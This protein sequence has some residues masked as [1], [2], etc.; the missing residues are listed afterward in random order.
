MRKLLLTTGVAVAALL[1]GAPAASAAITSSNVT[2]PSANPT[3]LDP[4]KT[5]ALVPLTVSGTAT[6]TG[7]VD[8]RC[9]ANNGAESFAIASNVAVS[10]GA[11]S[12][13]I[14]QNDFDY[15]LC[16]LIA[17]PTGTVPPH[18]LSSFRGPVVSNA[19]HYV[20]A[21]ETG[22]NAGKI[23]D[24]YQGE[25]A[26]E[27]YW[28]VYSAGDEFIGESYPVDPSS[29]GFNTDSLWDDSS[30][31]QRETSPDPS[32]RIDG[33]N[34]VL[35]YEVFDPPGLKGIENFQH[36]ID[37]SAGGVM[38]VSATEPLTFCEPADSP[39]NSVSDAG[40]RLEQSVVGGERGHTLEV[41]HRWV[42]SASTARQLDVTYNVDVDGI[43]PGW[44]SPGE[45]GY[46]AR[47]TDATFAPGG[48]GPASLFVMNNAGLA[49]QDLPRACGSLTWYQAPN[50][51]KWVSD[52]SV[53]L[54]YHRSIPAGG[55]TLIAFTY[56]QGF[57]QSQVDG[58]AAAAEKGYTTAFTIGKLTRKKKKGTATL[59]VDLPAAGAIH[60]EG[61][62]LKPVDLSASAAGTVSIPI[63]AKGKAKKKLK[64]KGRAKVSPAIT[65]TN[66]GLDPTS[67]STEVLLTQKK[68]KRRHR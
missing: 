54:T 2:N 13:S 17:V 64:R 55:S 21:I 65:Y 23:T 18:D 66:T 43:T 24:Y 7:N 35:P 68:K 6:G 22:D 36:S 45:T 46:T 48:T 56:S 31:P 30:I 29:L 39:C 61:K 60:M 47:A 40:M 62:N 57:P 11:F 42:N 10:G 33:R 67:Q 15:L 28:A 5:L 12:T 8:I 38:R 25:A 4:D 32:L 52:D 3:F 9:A 53:S 19:G 37:G 34:A 27:G 58:F 59:A 1:V 63:K 16:R 26:L 20:D 41:T 51:V 14:D 50:E 44:K 49:C